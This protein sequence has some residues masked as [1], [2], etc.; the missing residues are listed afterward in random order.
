[1]T[2]CTWR[3]PIHPGHEAR[4]CPEPG[5]AGIADTGNV[6]RL[7]AIAA[8]GHGRLKITYLPWAPAVVQEMDGRIPQSQVDAWVKEYG[9]DTDFVRIKIRGEFP[10]KE[11]TKP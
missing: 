8:R 10:A 7:H 2:P 3:S 9:R 11:E 1:M 6:C 4:P 5:T